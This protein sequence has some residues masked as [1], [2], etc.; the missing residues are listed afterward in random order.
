MPL[1]G[2]VL[3]PDDG[4]AGIAC[5]FLLRQDPSVMVLSVTNSHC[6]V[7]VTFSDGVERYQLAL[8]CFCHLQCCCPQHY[9]KGEAI[10]SFLS[11]L[12]ST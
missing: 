1:Q 7:S 4:V 12:L 10:F 11:K 3:G 9:H 8:L 2:P 6:S 5:M